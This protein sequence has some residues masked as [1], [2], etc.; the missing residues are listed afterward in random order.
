[1]HDRRNLAK[2]SIEI[3]GQGLVLPIAVIKVGI[4]QDAWGKNASI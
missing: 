4:V 3:H 1:M 2:L